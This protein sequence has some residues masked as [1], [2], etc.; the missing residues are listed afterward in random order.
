[1]EK[2]DRIL[3]L[4]QEMQKLLEQDQ[5]SMLQIP[6]VEDGYMMLLKTKQTVK[7]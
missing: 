1:M 6:T 2:N 4:E 5:N 3:V 7:E